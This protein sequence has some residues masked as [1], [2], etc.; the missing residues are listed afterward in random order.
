MRV[1]AGDDE[2]VATVFDVE[3]D[4]R[5]AGCR[6]GPS[7]LQRRQNRRRSS[8]PPI[9]RPATDPRR[10]SPKA[11]MRLRSRVFCA[12]TTQ[13]GGICR[14]A[15][16]LSGRPAGR[17]PAGG[18]CVASS[19]APPQPGR[20]AARRG[21][22]PRSKP[23]AR[24][25]MRRANPSA[26]EAEREAASR[27]E[28]KDRSR[29]VD[30]LSTKLRSYATAGEEA[31]QPAC[32]ATVPATTAPLRRRHLP[33]ERRPTKPAP[34]TA[35]PT[36]RPDARSAPPAAESAPPAPASQASRANSTRPPG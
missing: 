22:P 5:G 15:R 25:P 34:A 13:P 30:P 3:R 32:R 36:L 18:A 16:K 27:S 9:A 29:T 14:I 21:R 35:E 28:R 12:S 11:A 6:A 26:T 19:L 33:D 7:G 4:A 10:A 20:Q 23:S 24:S 31:K 1:R 17:P 8:F 2:T